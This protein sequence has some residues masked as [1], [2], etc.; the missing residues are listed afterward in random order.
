LN[1]QLSNSIQPKQ[2]KEF[3]KMNQKVIAG[4]F[5]LL[6]ALP[7]VC[8]QG[9]F[10]NLDFESVRGYLPPLGGGVYTTNAL[11]GWNAYYGTSQLSDIAYD[12][13]AAYPRVGLWDTNY[14]SFFIIQGKY[15]V[16][17]GG[18]S[19]SQSGLVTSNAQS[20]LFSAYPIVSG[21]TMSVFVGGQSLPFIAMS[22][23]PN[24]TVYGAD[25]AIFAG[26]TANLTFLA[27]GYMLDDVRFSEFPIPEPSLPGLVGLGACFLGARLGRRRLRAEEPH[28]E[29]G[30]EGSTPYS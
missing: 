22:S 6:S 16:S 30:Q 4:L 20:L 23:N 9:T 14:A 19:I 17:L 15:S 25:I 27:N 10:Q 12:V 11:P 26:Q 29:R 1:S 7:V 2:P 8:G 18:G 5:A 3:L 28:V 13:Y 24:Y 21:P